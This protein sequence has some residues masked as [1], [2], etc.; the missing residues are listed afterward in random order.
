MHGTDPGTGLKWAEPVGPGTE[1]FHPWNQTLHWKGDLDGDV[2]DMIECYN[3]RMPNPDSRPVC[4]HRFNLPEWG[5]WVDFN[6]PRTL[7]P[8]WK[9]LKTSVRDLILSFEVKS[10]DIANKSERSIHKES[11]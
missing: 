6:Y 2:S 1:R 4:R 11:D 10:A 3:G 5:A 7:L 9:S 8:Q